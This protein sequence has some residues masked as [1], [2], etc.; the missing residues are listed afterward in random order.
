MHNMPSLNLML[1]WHLWVP[2][3]Y[4]NSHVDT[5]LEPFYMEYF[6]TVKCMSVIK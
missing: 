3:V 1:Q 5:M 2:H 6:L 4:G